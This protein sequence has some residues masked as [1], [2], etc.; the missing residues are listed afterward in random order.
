[1]YK[2]GLP[3]PSPNRFVAQ[4]DLDCVTETARL[5]RKNVVTIQREKYVQRPQQ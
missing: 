1:V 4:F 3:E 5:G 2:L